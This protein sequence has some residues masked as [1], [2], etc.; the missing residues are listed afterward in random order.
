MTI[1]PPH[2]LAL[3]DDPD[4]LSQIVRATA[5]HFRVIPLTNPSRALAALET[6]PDIGVFIT[7][8]I[9]QFGNGIDLLE[10]ARTMKPNVRRVMLTN[11]NDLAS[12]IPGLHSGTIQAL[13]QTPATDQELLAAIAPQLLQQRPGARRL[14]A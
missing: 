4:M 3:N 14:S 11:Y 10:A 2:L 13:A 1:G 5:G 9:M 12:I 6:D 7:A 8:Q